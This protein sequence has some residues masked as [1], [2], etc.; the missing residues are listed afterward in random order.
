MII[1]LTG[2][3]SCG[4]T[5]L[6]EELSVQLNLPV[7]HEHARAYLHSKDAKPHYQPSDLV[8]LVKL[9]LLSEEGA[10]SLI[11]DTDLLTLIIWWR[12]KYGPVPDIFQ[13]AM[14][15]QRPRH[16]LLCAPD[17]A[18]QPDPLRENRNDRARLFEVY[19][20]ELELR[21]L[22]FDVVHGVGPS[23]TN[24]AMTALENVRA[25]PR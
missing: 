13:H 19:Q 3:E 4:K 16:Y 8:E 21:K 17:I 20:R 10:N 2:P 25:K 11:L 7:V 1:V 15:S 23:R 6:A 5:Q 18:W 14:R 12:E 9:Q 22:P 24:C